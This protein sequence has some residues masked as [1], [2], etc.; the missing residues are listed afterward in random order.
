MSIKALALPEPPSDNTSAPIDTVESLLAGER[1]IA[2]SLWTILHEMR[3]HK[4]LPD[5]VM[6][7]DGPVGSH[8]Q[9]DILDNIRRKTDVALS[10]LQ[11]EYEY[12][13]WDEK[14]NTLAG[15]FPSIREANKAADNLRSEYP[16]ARV[17]RLHRLD[18]GQFTISRRTY[19]V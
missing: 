16:T 13:V 7:M 10:G 5:W 4:Q 6:K 2:L 9:W 3:L 17:V 11:P 12:L 18:E 14:R 8:A 15:G 1:R 19:H